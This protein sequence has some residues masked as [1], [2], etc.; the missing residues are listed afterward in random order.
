MRDRAVKGKKEG[1]FQMVETPQGKFWGLRYKKIGASRKLYIS[2]MMKPPKVQEE[3]I[4]NWRHTIYQIVFELS[5][6]QIKYVYR[7]LFLIAN[8]SGISVDFFK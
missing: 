6:L 4:W 5:H 8:L 2:G 1:R 3:I 7:P